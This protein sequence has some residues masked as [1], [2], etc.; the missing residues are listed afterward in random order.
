MRDERVILLDNDEVCAPV[1]AADYYRQ[2]LEET[3]KE[4]AAVEELLK[5]YKKYFDDITSLHDCND[6]EKKY[7]LCEYRPKVN[8]YARINC[9]LWV[10]W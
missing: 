6:C 1:A 8:E 9:P 4:L 7:N 5:I 2:R 3:E 10:E